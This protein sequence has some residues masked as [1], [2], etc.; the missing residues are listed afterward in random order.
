MR[1]PDHPI[2]VAV[3][4]EALAR[5]RESA[6]ILAALSTAE[7]G[8]ESIGKALT[9]GLDARTMGNTLRCDAALVANLTLLRAMSVAGLVPEAV[10]DVAAELTAAR[11]E[12]ARQVAADEAQR[13][14][15]RLAGEA[16]QAAR[17]EAHKR[18]AQVARCERERT[19]LAG[20]G[21]TTG[22]A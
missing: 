22:S 4:G 13:E 9:H 8:D 10:M 2:Y 19:A 5:L 16:E 6:D 14:K 20:S 12:R 17:G 7:L 15:D 11:H 21:W 3:A 18:K 1:I